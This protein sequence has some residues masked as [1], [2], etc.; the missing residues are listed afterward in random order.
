VLI[1]KDK[2][3]SNAKTDKAREM[4]IPVLTKEEFLKQFKL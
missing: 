2:S 3:V 1:V 4:K